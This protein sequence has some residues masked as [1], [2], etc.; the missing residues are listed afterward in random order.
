MAIN[1]TKLEGLIRAAFPEAEFELKD[2]VGDEDHYHLT[3]RSPE[4]QGKNKVQQHQMVYKGLGSIVGTTLH[5][6][7]LETATKDL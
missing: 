6:L 5:A 4:F 2:L 7:S 3:I 1:Q